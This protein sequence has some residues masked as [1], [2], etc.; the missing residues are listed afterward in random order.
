MEWNYLLKG[1]KEKFELEET[2]IE[3]SNLNYKV[4]N[5]SGMDVTGQVPSAL[6]ERVGSSAQRGG[7]SMEVLLKNPT[8]FQID[9]E[10]LYNAVQQLG[11]DITFHSSPDMGYTSPYK[12]GRGRGFEIVQEYFTKYLRQM[13]SFKEEKEQREG[14]DFEISRINP[15]ISTGQL[16]PLE[17]QGPQDI[18]L[19]PFGDNI[20][21]MSE[22]KFS[23]RDDEGNNIYRNEEFLKKLY[24]VFLKEE[25]DFEYQ[26]YSLFSNF[27]K[28]FERKWAEARKEA[29]DPRF[30]DADLENKVSII[31]TLSAQ[32]PGIGT[33]WQDVL[34][35]QSF[36]EISLEQTIQ[37]FPP[38]ANINIPQSVSNLEEANRALRQL[39]GAV[40]LSQIRQLPSS[41]YT[42]SRS[43][44]RELQLIDMNNELEE[45]KDVT[46]DNL[47]EALK[48][49]WDEKEEDGDMYYLPIEGRIEAIGNRLEV[50][51]KRIQEE[52]YLEE[53][54]ELEEAALGVITNQEGY[55]EQDNED[56]MRFLKSISQNFEQAMWVESNLLYKII[57]AWMSSS[58]IEYR[59]DGQVVH[60]SF[61]GP[62]F[63]WDTL[64]ERKYDV[65]F[66]EEYLNRLE[67]D[68]EFRLDVGS[69]AAAV[70][71]WGHFT[72]IRNYFDTDDAAIMSHFEEEPSKLA[73]IEEDGW[74]WIKWMNEFGIGVNMETM[75]GNPQTYL[76]LWRPKDIVACCRGINITARNQLGEI[77]DELYDCPL[78]FTIDP[79]HTAS[80]GGDPMKH[81]NDLARQEEWVAE[82]MADK[83]PA[84]KDKPL[85]K[86]VRT[87]H[88]TKPGWET[89]QGVGHLH[90]GFRYGD[91]Q[92]YSWLHQMVMDG[93]GQ[94]EEDASIIYE[95]GGEQVGTVQKA[96]LSMNMI[97]LGISPDD[98]DPSKV[99]PG[100]KYRDERE[101]LMARFFNMDRP[102]YNREWAKIEQHAFDPLK[103]LLESSEF[104]H[105]WTS[106]AALNK[107]KQREFP[108]EEFK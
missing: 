96:K 83:V 24:E 44:E 64:I 8:S 45:L 18:G 53:K 42:I 67:E 11:L 21:E 19:G 39:T 52:A 56:Y 48:K 15:H 26:Y 50:S 43:L 82:N 86:M 51:P 12:T 34:R 70:Y 100:E 41:Y 87:Y 106:S 104:E 20:G 38:R 36:D 91:E 14:L 37:S 46:L 90:G 97:E 28:K 108:G 76:K 81:M 89:Q 7:S 57:P 105:T 16:P 6:A 1:L 61:E 62:K 73:E 88:L 93:F 33:K 27:S 77:N 4:G 54:E 79:E 29:L 95:I 32:D 65:D 69:A 78:K 98:L 71:V 55:F 59:K 84:D 92:L 66:G 5:T 9:R 107:G 40:N 3:L 13:A 80:F 30:N 10:P 31:T 49:L 22:E 99:N 58:H 94:A 74:T 25:V 47:A 68:E 85:A 103:G 60:K 72:Q 101:A 23:R 102:T 17:Q 2:D 35:E 75:Y 63:I